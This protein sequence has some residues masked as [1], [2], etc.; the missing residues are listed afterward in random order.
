[1]DVSQ[2]MS[3]DVIS[4]TPNEH[5]SKAMEKMSHRNCR[6]LAVVDDNG[7]LIG[8]LTERDLRAYNG[9]LDKTLVSAAM[10][11]GVIAIDE[12]T[13]ATSAARIL[14]DKKVGGLPVI[15]PNG[16]IVGIVTTSD[17]LRAFV[18]LEERE[19]AA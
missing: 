13:S 12:T 5:L 10:E 17:L 11:E 16:K 4:V 9:Y 3:R 1:M 8:V 14:I 19:N 15:R 18:D 6:H 2:W 7:E